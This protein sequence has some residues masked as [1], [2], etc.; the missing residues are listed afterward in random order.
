MISPS[1]LPWCETL[2]GV[3][4]RVGLDVNVARMVA[5]RARGL[6]GGLV[7]AV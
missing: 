3:D 7:G 4:V 1:C 2:S 5:E 6:R